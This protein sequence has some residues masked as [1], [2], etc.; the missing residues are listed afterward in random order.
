MQPIRSVAPAD[1]SASELQALPNGY[2]D[3]V[4]NEKGFRQIAYFDSADA[5]E[6]TFLTNEEYEVAETISAIDVRNR[7]VYATDSACSSVC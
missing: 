1:M 6:P 2:I 3:V 4:P 7:K 5:S